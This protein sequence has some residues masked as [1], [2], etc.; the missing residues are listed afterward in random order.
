MDDAFDRPLSTPKH[1]MDDV[2]HTPNMENCGSL[3]GVPFDQHKLTCTKKYKCNRKSCGKCKGKSI[4]KVNQFSL[5]YKWMKGKGIV[6]MDGMKFN[7]SRTDLQNVFKERGRMSNLLFLP[8]LLATCEHWFCVVINLVEKHIDVLDSMKLKSDGKTQAIAD[9]VRLWVLHLKVYGALDWEMNTCELEANMG[10]DMRKRLLVRF[11]LSPH[12]NRRND[13][14]EKCSAD[15]IY[16]V[17]R[18][19]SGAE[20]K[21]K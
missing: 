11:I 1:L 16:R 15:K 17:Q 9:V 3:S 18:R 14:Q 21:G 12:N 7:P 13:V 2:V 20:K 5:K 10:I 6:I 19:A 8:I 4:E